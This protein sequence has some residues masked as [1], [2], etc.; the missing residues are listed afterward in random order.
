MQHTHKPGNNIE[1][2]YNEYSVNELYG[3]D[4]L[5]SYL[6][7]KQFDIQS[8]F[9]TTTGKQMRYSHKQISKIWDTILS[10][11]IKEKKMNLA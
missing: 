1:N 6:K 10:A 4:A 9:T 2:L 5:A 3:N 11:L 7:V 8:T